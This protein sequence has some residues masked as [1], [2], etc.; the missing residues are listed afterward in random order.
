MQ[1]LIP[2]VKRISLDEGMPSLVGNT[3]LLPL[4]TLSDKTIS[5][6]Q[7][8]AKAEWFN[9]SGSVKDRPAWGIIQNALHKGL[10][11]PGMHL[12]DST[13]GNM[14]IAYATFGSALGIPITLA[15][16]SN[17]SPERVKI[18]SALGAELVLTDPLEGSDG[19]IL[20]AQQ[21]AAD[22]PERYYY[23]NQYDNPANWKSHYNS[24]GPE[25]IEQTNG[26]VT[27]VVLGMGTTGTL[28][29]VSRYLKEN[30]P[31][32]QVI[33]V[34]PDS[35][36]NGLEGLK[37]MPS[38]IQPGIYDPAAADRIVHI[39]TEDAYDMVRCLAR[40]EGYFIGISSGAAAVAA[41]QVANELEQGVVVTV[42]PD[43]GFKYL[44][45]DALWSDS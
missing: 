35:P 2:Y 4:V 40:E 23:A 29:G 31:D 44:S 21:M 9:P 14:G 38:A 20:I 15:M 27:H 16:P 25:I 1:D 32:V 24:T 41:R 7:V 22:H 8:F 10:I 33:G 3:P 17:A 43:A 30:Y 12:L 6:V 39:R 37:H 26:R 34:Q 36:F 28:T 19:A 5:K 42:F 11:L 45:D 13:S 18:M